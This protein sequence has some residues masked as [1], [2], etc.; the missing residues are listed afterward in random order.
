MLPYTMSILVSA[1]RLDPSLSDAS[2]QAIVSGIRAVV[3]DKAVRVRIPT[4]RVL[5][6][7]GITQTTLTRRLATNPLY[8]KL[9]I[10]REPR[11][12]FYFLDQVEAVRDGKEPQP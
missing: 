3:G 8:R 6:I 12:C 1:L 4:H 7:L 10:T 11:R 2:R 9:T 5:E